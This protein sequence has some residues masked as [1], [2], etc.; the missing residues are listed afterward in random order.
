MRKRVHI[1]LAVLLV[2]LA[3]VGA[4]HTYAVPPVRDDGAARFTGKAT[5]TT[6]T[7][8]AIAAAQPSILTM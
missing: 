6:A 7:P 4:W 5:T 3:G 1:V 8:K 2:I